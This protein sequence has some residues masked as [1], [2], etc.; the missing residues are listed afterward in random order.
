MDALQKARQLRQRI[1]DP[2]R[3][4]THTQCERS[5]LSEL[6]QTQSGRGGLISLNSLLSQTE[7]TLSPAVIQLRDWLVSGYLDTLPD[8]VPGFADNLAPYRDRARLI[9]FT[10]Q[11]LDSA[12]WS[13]TGEERAAQFVA[14]LAPLLSHK[15]AV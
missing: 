9:D 6:S 14:V 12:P 4:W 1:P 8:P 2:S 5:E 15:A 10:R 3:E 11:I 7:N 13:L